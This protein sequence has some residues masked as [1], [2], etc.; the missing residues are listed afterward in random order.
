MSTERVQY[1]VN[2]TTGNLNV[3]GNI[4]GTNIVSTTLSSGSLQLSGGF[5]SSGAI[6]AKGG[7]GFSGGNT[8]CKFITGTIAAATISGS[9][10]GQAS[11]SFNNNY[12]YSGTPYMVS[13]SIVGGNNGYYGIPT[14]SS[15]NASGGYYLVQNYTG[16]FSIT[17]VLGYIAIGPA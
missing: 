9:A 10:I 14:L 17:P 1:N 3:I 6:L 15:Y 7:I 13:I 5:T 4:T 8:A 11:F 12:Y 16:A 2:I